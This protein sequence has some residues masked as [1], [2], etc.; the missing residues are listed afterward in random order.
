MMKND[1]GKLLLFV[2]MSAMAFFVYEMWIDLNYMTDLIHAYIQMVM[3]H[4]R[5]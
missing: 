5:P 4:V 2:W 1:L 3:E